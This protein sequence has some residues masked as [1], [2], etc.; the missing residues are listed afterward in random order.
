MLSAKPNLMKLF[1]DDNPKLG[2][3]S[4]RFICDEGIIHLKHLQNL[5]LSNCNMGKDGA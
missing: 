3:D 5:H 2:S 1:L 4:I